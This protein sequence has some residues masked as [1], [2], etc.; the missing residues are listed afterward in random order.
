MSDI[1]S[2][3]LIKAVNDDNI[4]QLYALFKKGVNIN[5]QDEN[6]RTVL[7]TAVKHNNT[8][9]VKV[10]IKLGGLCYEA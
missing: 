9:M 3:Q 4:P 5:S 7:H 2:K 6:G 8:D 10:L 1:N